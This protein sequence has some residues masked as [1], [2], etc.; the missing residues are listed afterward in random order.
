MAHTR[1]Y[2]LRCICTEWQGTISS[3]E[4]KHASGGQ[5]FHW[6]VEALGCVITT[7]EALSMS[8]AALL[9]PLK[10]CP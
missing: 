3:R 2:F 8:R 4:D 1:F 9:Q 5:R 7:S 10:L 6:E